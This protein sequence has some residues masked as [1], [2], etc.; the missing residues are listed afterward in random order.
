MGQEWVEAIIYGRKVV[1]D[2]GVIYPA[3]GGSRPE[4]F[5]VRWTIDG[6]ER[7]RTFINQAGG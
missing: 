4:E 7:S 3:S 5:I 2:M 1:V 6:E